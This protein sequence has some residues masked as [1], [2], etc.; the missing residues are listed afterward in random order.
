MQNLVDSLSIQLKLEMEVVDT[1]LNRIG[2]SGSL[3]GLAGTR[4]KRGFINRHVLEEG[5][6]MLIANP[7]RE[8]HCS[9]CDLRHS[10]SYRAGLAC[11][12]VRQG[13][14][15]GVFDL[16]GFEDGGWQ[17]LRQGDEHLL[18]FIGGLISG[19]V[20]GQIFGDRSV[21]QHESIAA[22]S[23]ALQI[24]RQTLRRACSAA[25]A[26]A[27]APTDPFAEIFGTSASL[28]RVVEKA[29][30]V[31]RRGD[32]ILLIGETGTGKELFARAIH[33]ASPA[34]RGSLVALNCS[35]IPE[36]LLESE[37]FGYEEG[38]FTGA[39]RGGKA[40]KFELADGGTLFL[41][42]VSEL[43]LSLQP[44]L[45][46]VL[47]RRTVERVGGTGYR[48]VNIQI[49]AACNC[50]LAERVRQGKFRADLYYR[51]K[52]LPIYLP[53]LRERR[54]DI[55]LLAEHFLAAEAERSGQDLKRLSGTAQEALLVYDWPGN[56]RELKNA[57]E[58]AALMEEGNEISIESLP[59]ELQ[60]G[61]RG[62]SLRGQ[63]LDYERQLVA[64]ALRSEG[65]NVEGKRRVA[66]QMGVSLPT[67]Y[68]RL[69]EL[70][71]S[72]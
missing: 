59:D 17:M 61:R 57:V 71:L 35:A 30:R 69:K 39:R 48:P 34:G 10:C 38:A 44:K 6:P 23:T 56:V 63:V 16:M 7:G 3:R 13:H 55:P 41:D 67:L 43:P 25:A 62:V 47:E 1:H 18:S 64:A 51:L 28:Q 2:V 33:R 72:D 31:A 32:L 45:L 27:T 66:N 40:G 26:P 46:R 29:R 36:S 15:V 20:T 49:I 60:D 65:E 14:V 53:P 24:S 68:R 8:H 54:D 12:I 37:L 21:D 22:V 58:Y 42:E 11:P 4:Q 50:D 9:P 5:K 70:G 52:G 19:L